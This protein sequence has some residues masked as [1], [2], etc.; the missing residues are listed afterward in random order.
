MRPNP[1]TLDQFYAFDETTGMLKAAYGCEQ[2]PEL[3]QR[4]GRAYYL[5]K[6]AKAHPK[7]RIAAEDL[8]WALATGKW[9]EIP[10]EP[11]DGNWLN[12]LPENWIPAKSDPDEFREP[13]VFQVGP[14]SF[15]VQRAINGKLKYFGTFPSVT[16]ANVRAR[17]IREAFP[18]KKIGRPP[19]PL[20]ERET[21]TAPKRVSLAVEKARL[22]LAREQL[23]TERLRLAA[24][25]A[26]LELRL[27]Q[28]RQL[29]NPGSE[30]V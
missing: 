22:D 10:L 11:V 26:E 28:M 13:G 19:K 29:E 4:N 3:I 14:S 2:Q 1:E 7:Q 12:L 16:S 21:R 17:A 8:A 18:P 24:E 20:A 9:P 25:K 27:A 23:E 5:H 6:A 15:R 30:A